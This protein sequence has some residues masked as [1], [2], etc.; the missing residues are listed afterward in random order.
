NRFDRA[1]KQISKT[2]ISAS[3]DVT[4][5]PPHLLVRL[6]NEEKDTDPVDSNN[7]TA[8]S[9]NER[10]LRRSYAVDDVD[11]L[12]GYGSGR[13]S[14]WGAHIYAANR[15]SRFSTVASRN[16]HI[17]VDSRA[18]LGCLQTNNNSI[19]G[20]LR[21]QS[22]SFAYSYHLPTYD[23]HHVIPCRPP[24]IVTIEYYQ[25]ATSSAHQDRTLGQF[26]ELLAKKATGT[27]PDGAMCGGKT[28]GQHVITYTHNTG[29]ISVTSQEAKLVL[30]DHHEHDND[31]NEV[32]TQAAGKNNR[33]YMWT[34][35]IACNAATHIIPM[36]LASWNY[37]LAKYLELLYYNPYFI[38]TLL[39]DHVAG[40]RGREVLR[41]CFRYRDRIVIF[42]YDQIDLFEMRLPK[43]QISPDHHIEE[44]VAAAAK[45][46]KLLGSATNPESHLL[47]TPATESPR[48]TQDGD[49]SSNTDNT[50]ESDSDKLQD[51]TGYANLVTRNQGTP[52]QVRCQL[53]LDEMWRRYKADEEALF[54]SIVPCV[55]KMHKVNDVR[56]RFLDKIDEVIKEIGEWTA[57]R[58]VVD[59]PLPTPDWQVPEYC[60]AL[61]NVPAKVHVYPNSFVLV[62]EDEPT[63]IIAFTLSSKDYIREARRRPPPRLADEP[64][65]PST[66][67]TTA[68]P[69]TPGAELHNYLTP[70]PS[71]SQKSLS[72]HLDLHL[73]SRITEFRSK[74]HH[75]SLTSYYYHRFSS[76]R[77]KCSISSSYITSLSRCSA[78]E[79]V[80]GGKSRAAFFKTLDETLVIKELT[81]GKW[82]WGNVEKGQLLKFA[83]KYLEYME[84][85]DKNPT[86]LVK[87]FGFYTIKRKNVVTGAVNRLDVLVMEHLFANVNIS[88]KFDLKGIPDRHIATK[89]RTTSTSNLALPDEQSSTSSSSTTTST[90]VPLSPT[91]PTPSSD[92][93]VLW[94][95]E[96]V[97]GRYTQHIR[98]HGHSK[99]ILTA[100]IAS[101][102]AFLASANIM[103]YSLL[104]GVNDAR[105]E[106]VVGIVD[107]VGSYTW[108]KS[109]ES[110]AKTTISGVL[111]MRGSPVERQDG[112]PVGEL[113]AVTIL[114]PD[115]YA[116]RFRRAMEQNF[117]M[118]P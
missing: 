92:V 115:L 96:W 66:T 93:A 89:H 97:S 107:F 62:R 85:S 10:D 6:R 61:P 81:G 113:P 108:Y 78:W 69:T 4:F 112:S 37:S 106:L 87:I 15:K 51:A 72:H 14:S 5:P 34:A 111:A 79:S 77:R 88:R 86:V 83:P 31:E 102:T 58:G 118:V 94:D 103:D 105:K 18:G 40:E 23:N 1:I 13:F 39:C 59:P 50:T 55:D 80:S 104:V 68:L 3:P 70:Q 30:R 82:S 38:P 27:C 42:G 114:P 29:R 24:E 8:L 95:G 36:S 9:L 43:I 91:P 67:T 32:A 73:T 11:F 45:T 65:D 100:C 52:D 64:N 99:Q 35:C 90:L 33:I 56:K 26:V 17:S 21:H 16:S 25:K 84:R 20:V 116:E 22:I 117:L 53:M 63:S 101:D 110:K 2:I 7:D 41:R 46:N 98:L 28:M 12:T 60:K 75:T 57:E 48:D 71:P 49:S 74:T 47:D 109:I 19:V 76:L 44:A 54:D